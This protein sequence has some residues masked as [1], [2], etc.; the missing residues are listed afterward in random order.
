VYCFFCGAG[1][2]QADAH[3]PGFLGLAEQVLDR[4]RALPDSTPRQLISI[5]N[6]LR[7]R[8]VSGVGSILAADRLFGLLE[9]DFAQEDINGA[10]GEILRPNANVD[11]TA[12]RIIL[13]LSRTPNGRVQIVTTNFDL[14]FEMV[15]R[16]A[17]KWTPNNLP[18]LQRGEG[19]EGIVHLHGVFDQSYTKAVG[20]NLVLSS[21]EFGRAYLA[22]GWA[23]AFIRD[24]IERY[25]IVFVGYSADD[26]PVQYLLEAL[27]RVSDRPHRQL[28]AFQAGHE[29]EAAALWSH[30]GVVAIPYSTP[31]AD[32]GAMWT[33]L[34]AWAE[35][36]RDPEK[37]RARVL[38]RG[39]QGP[40]K[41]AP[42]ER[43]QVMHLAMIEDGVKTIVAAKRALPATWLRVFDRQSV[44]R[45]LVLETFSEKSQRPN[46]FFCMAL[47]VTRDQ[48]L[49]R[50]ILH[51]TG[52]RCRMVY[53][54][55]SLPTYWI[56]RNQF[57]PLSAANMQITSRLC[58]R[59]C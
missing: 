49:R 24:A 23:T 2:S 45:R 16:A 51:I 11:L 58:R 25:S 55:L 44:M 21:A 35:R 48:R 29:A 59:A 47:T 30:K 41:M 4:L 6:R 32:H 26:P 33:T 40:E 19:F 38:Q 9:R 27:N 42:H 13:D 20:G 57:L 36:A 39:M 52:L 10:V 31:S 18:D 46:P 12:H 15:A 56:P 43:G 53:W 7:E 34:K 5:A 28:Y 1:V 14:L 37:W 8:K 54:M 22:E 17:P 3:L 50:S